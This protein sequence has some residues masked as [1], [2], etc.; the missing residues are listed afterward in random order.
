L[1]TKLDSAYSDLLSKSK[2]TIVLSTAQGI[3]RWDM[4]TMMPPKAV[5]QRSQ[6]LALLSRL[7]HKLGT[8]PEIGRLLATVQTSSQYPTMGQVEKRNVYHKQKLP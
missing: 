8:D 3:I 1:T 6:Q 4:E 5:E 2:D 7:H